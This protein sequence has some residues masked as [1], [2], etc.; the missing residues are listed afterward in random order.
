M[1]S[2]ERSAIHIS[3]DCCF[4]QNLMPFSVFI[5]M[6]ECLV[7][8]TF[9]EKYILPYEYLYK[10]YI[11]HMNFK[12]QFTFII[13]NDLVI[14]EIEVTQNQNDYLILITIDKH[15][16][17]SNEEEIIVCISTKKLLVCKYVKY[18][19]RVL[20]IINERVGFIFNDE[21]DCLKTMSY[22]N[23][24]LTTEDNE[25]YDDELNI[26]DFNIY[27]WKYFKVFMNEIIKILKTELPFEYLIKIYRD[28]EIHY[29]IKTYFKL[30]ENNQFELLI[31]FQIIGI[32][33]CHYYNIVLHDEVMLETIYERGESVYTILGEIY[34]Y[35][36]DMNV[37]TIN[38]KY[39]Q[40]EY[41]SD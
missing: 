3:K 38:T 18:L 26:I 5:K 17:T 20:Q 12:K 24:I 9:D 16:I 23:E 6:M 27:S 41:D 10:M 33:P 4:V 28:D 22:V 40:D 30:N 35:L 19:S 11:E 8:K 34:N 2:N 32:E 39:F 14:I 21:F 31:T 13:N 7:G 15:N 25:D 1:S 29:L 37:K 36:K